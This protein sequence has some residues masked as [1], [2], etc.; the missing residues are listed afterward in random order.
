MEKEK[1]A[2][3][4][5]KAAH[6]VFDTINFI[7][8]TVFNQGH[9]CRK[10][11]TKL[12]TMYHEE[13]LYS[14]HCPVCETVTLVKAG[15]PAKAER[16]VGLSEKEYWS[17]DMTKEEAIHRIREHMR[18]HRIGEYPHIYIKQ[19]LDMAINALLTQREQPRENTEEG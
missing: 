9:Y 11:G 4:T 6:L 1:G 5:D 15:S 3:T 12:E 10:C 13:R 8:A 17:T 16:M 2:T 18:V 7:H 14:V 19:A